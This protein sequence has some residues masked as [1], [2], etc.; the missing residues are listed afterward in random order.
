MIRHQLS[1]WLLLIGLSLFTP[2]AASQDMAIFSM[3][4][5]FSELSKS[6]ARKLYRGKTKRLSGK[7]FELS[8][9]PENSPERLGFYEALLGKN[10]AQMNAHWAS[11][12]F[13]GKARPPKEITTA[14]IESLLDWMSE[15][16]SRIGYA[17]LEQLPENA[18][19]LYVVSTEK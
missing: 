2:F 19:I 16:S 15:K 10:S 8:D 11:L 7:R 18:T 9:W 1:V 6:K 12:S 4:T 13:S 5:G 3:D 17:P 14:D